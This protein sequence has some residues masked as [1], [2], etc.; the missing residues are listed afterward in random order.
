[1]SK[2]SHVPDKNIVA[3]INGRFHI[4]LTFLPQK[5]PNMIEYTGLTIKNNI[6][7]NAMPLHSPA[8]R[9]TA[10]GRTNMTTIVAHSQYIHV[11][12]NLVFIS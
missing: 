12:S 4:C 2:N 11:V 5:K 1:M 6:M 9:A 10:K 3:E 7:H 8:R